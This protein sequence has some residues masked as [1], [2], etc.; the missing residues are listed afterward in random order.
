MGLYMVAQGAIRRD[1]LLVTSL[2]REMEVLAASHA[3]LAP[4]APVLKPIAALAGD[5][6]CRV[7]SVVSINR[8]FAAIARTLDAHGRHLPS[9]RGC[10]LL[11]RSQVF[12]LASHPNS[13]DSR[14]WGP[15]DARLARGIARPLLTFVK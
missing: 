2:P 8:R 1:D 15:V 7:G 11:S 5:R 10:R 14:Y 12:L 13:F 9:W 3:I 4:G 6:V